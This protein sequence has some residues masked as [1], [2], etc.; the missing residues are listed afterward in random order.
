[1]GKLLEL[2]SLL[3]L[4]LKLPPFVG[5]GGG[6]GLWSLRGKFLAN[7]CVSAVDAAAVAMEAGR[8]LLT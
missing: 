8:G 1:M 4:L 6:I 7:S 2:A 5:S 3:L